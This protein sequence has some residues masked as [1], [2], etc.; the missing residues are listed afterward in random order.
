MRISSNDPDN[1]VFEI[2]LAATASGTLS[3][4][5]PD[6]V[7]VPLSAIAFTATGS[8][9]DLSLNYLPQTGTELTLVEITG[10]GSGIT[11][12]AV[13]VAVTTTGVLAGK[14][15]TAIAAGDQHSMALCKDGTVVSWGNNNLGLVAELATP[16]IEEWRLL[17]FQT[18]EN[19]EIAADS[20]SPANDG[21][22]NL[23]KFA[24]GMS[25]WTAGP[26]RIHA[27]MDGDTLFFTYP[28]SKAAL[29]D[30]LDF[31]IEA[32]HDLTAGSW[33]MLGDMVET[34]Q[35][36]GPPQQVTV[37]LQAQSGPFLFLLLKVQALEP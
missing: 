18:R 9:V 3:A 14:F 23:M 32:S 15:V 1:G 29:A 20:A 11:S 2:G 12:S 37:T 25:P 19:S 13:P 26:P 28:R 22:T 30:G 21:V 5:W 16:R 10:I 7:A 33:Q 34:I 17:H 27:P 6:A 36:S 8:E 31:R 4:A 24:T 35:D